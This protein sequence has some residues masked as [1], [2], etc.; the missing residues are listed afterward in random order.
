MNRLH[1]DYETRSEVDLRTA[2]AHKYAMHESTRVLMLGWAVNDGPVNLWEPH[3]EPL[4]VDLAG[5]ILSPEYTNVAFN[6]TFERLITEHVLG[7][8]T[9]IQ[10]WRC[11]MIEAYYLGFAGGLDQIL[12]AIGLEKK[13]KRGGQL[14][15]LFCTPA[16][17]NHKATWYDHLNRSAEWEEFCNYC[18]QDVKVERQLWHWLRQFPTMAQWDWDRYALDQKIND[19]GVPMNTDMAHGAVEMWDDEKV[20]LTQALKNVTGLG[21]VTREPFAAWLQSRNCEVDNLQKETLSQV[22]AL[23]LTP[24]DVKQAIDLWLQK[25]AKAVSKYVAVLKGTCDDGRARGMFQFKGASRTDRTSGRRIQ[26]Q[27]LKRAFLRMDQIDYVV[28]LVERRQRTGLKLLTGKTVADT[29]GGSIRH[30]IKAPEG[31]ALVVCDLTSIESVVLGWLCYCSLIDETFRAGRDS[32]RVFA[33]KYFNILYEE[34]T[35]EQRSFSKPP[36]LGCFAS[37]TQV[38]T[39]QGWVRV[40]DIRDQHEVWDGVEWVP[41]DGAVFQGEKEIV[42]RSGVWAT[43]D[44]KVLAGDGW[45]EWK[46]L[47]DENLKK[48]IESGS[49]P[50]SDTKTGELSRKNTGAAKAEKKSFKTTADTYDVLNAGPR[51]R[52]TIR[53]ED[54][55]VI[56]HNCGYMLGWRGLIAYSEGYGV[57]MDEESARAAVDT[58]RGMYPEIPEFWRWIEKAVKYVIQSGNS[59]DGYRL[60]IERDDHFLR[61]WLPSGR[62][63]SYYQ[64]DVQMRPAPWDASKEIAN[65]CYMGTND[66]NQWCRIFAHAGL[67]TENIVQSIAM[68]ILFHGLTEADKY[69]MT[70][71]LQVHDE[72]GCEESVAEANEKLELLRSCMTTQPSWAQDMWLG[73]DGYVCKHYTKD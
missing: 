20:D 15:N 11:T 12:S 26:L 3:K 43:P 73:A 19:R 27:N 34:V 65:I 57:D 70:P 7:L 16:P 31:K 64:P 38:L 29:L 33:M 36:V 52:F 18:R 6:A 47:V 28:S 2:G 58:F 24:P 42:E 61:I 25:E 14:I 37:D 39:K 41:C 45:I 69:G 21:K 56:V 5:Y 51:N 72:I 4:P 67:F 48:A 50:C 1:L 30:V 63:L 17:K 8:F 46:D 35:K 54:G 49:G 10:N 44:H 13:D 60:H 40:V 22:A 66:K 23:P 68:D 55:P 62:A 59:L 9:P 53:T 32:Y 71:V